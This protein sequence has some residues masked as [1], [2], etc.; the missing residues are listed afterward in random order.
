MDY[1]NLKYTNQGI[2]VISSIFTVKNGKFKVLLINR[3]NEPFKGKWALVGGALYN[4]ETVEEGLKR[5]V[6]EKVGLDGISF[7][8]A[9]IYSRVDRA[10]KIRMLGL[11]YIAVIDAEKVEIVRETTHT[12]NAEWWNI[13]NLPDM[14]Y[15]H[16]EIVKD[17]V[18]F[19]KDH[20]EE[21]IIYKNL[22]PK[23]FTLPE[24]HK[25][26]ENMLGIELDRRNFR[27]KLLKDG[28]IVDTEKYLIV[29]NKKPSKLYK[30]S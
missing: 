7:V 13:D 17:A 25:A 12:N 28:K 10:P 15:D 6:F 23:E 9:G 4:D 8:H 3:K 16:E 22:F 11:S 30:F 14:A 1:K 20:I 26:F 5:E 18:K 24:F 27:K 19:L 29:P 21:S 2:H